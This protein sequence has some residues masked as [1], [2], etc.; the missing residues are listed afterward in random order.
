MARRGPR[1]GPRHTDPLNR[2][3]GSMMPPEHPFA[4]LA[5][6]DARWRVN[7]FSIFAAVEPSLRAA[8]RTGPGTTAGSGPDRASPHWSYVESAG[9]ELSA[10]AG[11]LL[12]VAPILLVGPRAG[13]A[14]RVLQATGRVS[15]LSV[16]P[17][18][19]FGVAERERWAESARQ[20]RASG[21]QP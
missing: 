15:R 21:A 10:P 5:A 17:D 16:D 13:T 6:P 8:V 3:I 19:R 18:G 9:S 2:P 20:A 12:L 7:A 1:T 11:R 4:V 14:V